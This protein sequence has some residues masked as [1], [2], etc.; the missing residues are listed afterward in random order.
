[1]WSGDRFGMV[2]VDLAEFS[3]LYPTPR[4]VRF[5]G[6]RP[7]GSTVTTDFTTDGIIDGSGPLPDFQTFYFDSRFSDLVRLEVPTPDWA[8]DNMAFS[9]VVPEPGTTALVLLAGAVAAFRLV[10]LRGRKGVS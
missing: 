1:M 8:L 7:D 2:S 5:V 10:K 9:Y 3:T 4:T 6:Y